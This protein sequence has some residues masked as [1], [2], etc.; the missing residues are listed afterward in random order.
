MKEAHYL[1]EGRRILLQ[2]A[3][4]YWKGLHL[5]RIVPAFELAII[6]CRIF[7]LPVCCPNI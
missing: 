1:I 4:S 5:L 2:V 7:R 6:R 3:S